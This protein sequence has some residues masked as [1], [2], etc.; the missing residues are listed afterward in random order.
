M[1]KVYVDIKIKAVITADE[2]T[3]TEDIMQDMCFNC[4]NQ[5]ADIEDWSIE[6]YEVTDSK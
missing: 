6:E 4:E 2:G 1:R 5:S 3:S